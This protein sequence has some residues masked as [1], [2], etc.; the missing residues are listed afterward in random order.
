MMP[1]IV[2]LVEV[3]VREGAGGRRLLTMPLVCDL[4]PGFASPALAPRRPMM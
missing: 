1:E 3:I 2:R 4:A